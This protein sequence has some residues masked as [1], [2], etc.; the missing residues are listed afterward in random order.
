MG[1]DVPIIILSAYNWSRIEEEAREAGVDGFI[2]KPL[3]RSKLVYLF[4]QLTGGEENEGLEKAERPL[5]RNFTG[6]RVLL[7]EDNELNR[8]IAEE[9]IGGTGAMIES[10]ENGRLAVERFEDVEDGYYDL[11]FMDIQMP[12]MNGY[13]AARAIRGS[14]KKDGKRIPIIAMTAN[15]FVDDVMDSK[16]AGMNEHIAKP[17][18]FD[19]LIECMNRWLQ[20]EDGKGAELL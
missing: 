17:L 3:F 7:V 10:V 13:E 16:R 9:V 11:I 20:T 2:S 12:V 5:S 6:S 4:K 8:E 18:D 15:A 14:A 1:P 19:R